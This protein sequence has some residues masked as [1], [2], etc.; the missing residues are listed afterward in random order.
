MMLTLA[1]LFLLQDLR[2]GV[3][4]VDA[5]PPAFPVVVNGHF[6]E[7]K[8][9]K[10]QDPIEGPRALALEG[11]S[12]GSRAVAL[13]GGRLGSGMPLGDEWTVEAWVWRGHGSGRF[14]GDLILDEKIPLRT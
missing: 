3:S 9:T 5:T 12:H 2:A 11:H 4:V 7:R 14:L 13:A 8:A 6:T 10:V 1:A